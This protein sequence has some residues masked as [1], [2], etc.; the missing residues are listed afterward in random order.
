MWTDAINNKYINDFEIVLPTNNYINLEID[1]FL[2]LF[3]IQNNSG[4]NVKTIK[5]IYFLLRNIIYNG[6]KKCILY[7]TSKEQAENNQ[8]IIQWM[9]LLFNIEINTGIIDYSLDRNKRRDIINNFIKS[10]CIYIL[11]NIHILDEGID[12]PECDSVCILKPNDN[13]ENIVQRINRCNRIMNNK[14][15][16]YIYIWSNKN[17]LDKIMKYINDLTNNELIKKINICSPDIYCG[18]YMRNRST[19]KH[20]YIIK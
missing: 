16:S 12:I 19:C 20:K 4:H 11:L 3:N 17:K 1:E 14:H 7:S 13:I 6:N 9:S 10:E 18:N 5:K 8:K 2:K 15:K